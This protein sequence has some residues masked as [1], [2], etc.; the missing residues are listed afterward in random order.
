L[1]YPSFNG[2]NVTYSCGLLPISTTPLALLLL[3]GRPR[4]LVVH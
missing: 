2:S 1:F 3:R 4:D